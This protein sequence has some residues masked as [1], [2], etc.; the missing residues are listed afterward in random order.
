[1]RY[2]NNRIF[3]LRLRKH[4]SV[5]FDKRTALGKMRQ[6]Y[7][8]AEKL[9]CRHITKH[10]IYIYATKDVSFSHFQLY[11]SYA[12]GSNKKLLS[13]VLYKQQHV[14]KFCLLFRNSNEQNRHTR[15]YDDVL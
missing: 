2:L 3:I 15:N 10:F 8:Q 6:P 5:W 14:C 12:F 4:F 1:M 13:S 9:S 7:R 11:T